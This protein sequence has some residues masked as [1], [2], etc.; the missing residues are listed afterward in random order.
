MRKSVATAVMAGL[1]VI[2][3]PAGARSDEG[4]QAQNPLQPTC[5]YTVTHTSST[6]ITGVAGAGDWIV[7]V[8]R[9]VKT[10][11]YESPSD[12]SP[13][14][15]EIAFKPGDK[16]KAEAL[17]PGSGLTVGHVDP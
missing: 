9:G 10:L 7:K 2:P 3:V 6:P 5:S 12:G 1:L 4:C 8:K 14:A 11:V 17:T 15:L 16:V 13:T